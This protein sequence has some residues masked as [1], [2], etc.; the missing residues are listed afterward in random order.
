MKNVINVNKKN[1]NL[2]DMFFLIHFYFM[3]EA[4]ISVMNEILPNTI[5]SGYDVIERNLV[6]FIQTYTLKNMTYLS[7]IF[8]YHSKFNSNLHSG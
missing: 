7:R 5:F 8:K 6:N 3:N 1:M 4:F 2:L